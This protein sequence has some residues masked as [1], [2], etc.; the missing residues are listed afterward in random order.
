MQH[1]IVTP[2]ELLDETGNLTQRG[3]M[4]NLLLRYD[5][6]RIK[7]PRFMI[8]EWDYYYI[9]GGD[10]GLALTVADNGYLA[11]G[12]VTLFDFA[13]PKEDSKSVMAP[14]PLGKLG[15]PPS[16]Q[17]GNVRFAQNG[18]NL[19]FTKRGSERRLSVQVKDFKDGKFLEGELVLHQP[20]DMD[21]MVIA[22]PFHKP[23]CFYYNQKINCMPATGELRL[24]EQAIVFGQEPAFGVLDWGRGVWTYRNTWYWGSAS[25]L[26]NGIPFG[27]NIG[28]GFGDTSAA[29]ENMLFY[30]GKAHKLDQVVFY[31]PPDDFLKPW[32]FSSSDGRFEMM[33][34]PVLDRASDT[35]VLLIRSNQHQVFGRFSGKA[36]LDGGET[37]VLDRFPGFAE[38]VAN[39]W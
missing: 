9:M 33:F 21:S 8:K 14:F 7:A 2:G 11:M 30:Q 31:I 34:E 35:N 26:V 5:R 13:V 27:F 12:S 32:Q 25:G 6:G 4:R 29:S 39:R 1:E 23:R 16:S 3:W 28:Y 38:K 37:I 10:A 36:V 19:T 22:T 24:G 15:M 17:E 18:M 20:E